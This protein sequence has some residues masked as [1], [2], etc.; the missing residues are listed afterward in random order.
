M[1]LRKIRPDKKIPYKVHMYPT[2]PIIAILGGIFVVLSTLL[3]QP[4]NA[5]LES[6]T[7][8]IGL[9]VYGYMKK[10]NLVSKKE[11]TA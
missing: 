2:I 11:Y 10:K 3:S 8:L 6:I 4:P 1:K 9:P 5:I 7:T